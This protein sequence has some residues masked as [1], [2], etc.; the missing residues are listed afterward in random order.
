M[1]TVPTRLQ[2]GQTGAVPAST[3]RSPASASTLHWNVKAD[4]VADTNSAT[5]LA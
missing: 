2:L 1:R 4:P 5:I 3:A